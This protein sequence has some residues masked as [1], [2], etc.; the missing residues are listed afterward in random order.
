MKTNNFNLPSTVTLAF[1]LANAEYEAEMAAWWAE[2]WPGRDRAKH[3]SCTTLI[4]SPYINWLEKKYPDCPEDY[5]DIYFSVLGTIWHKW[6]EGAARKDP[7][8]A[9]VEHRFSV[10]VDGWIVSGKIDIAR[11]D[12]ATKHCTLLM[13]F[14]FSSFYRIQKAMKRG[15]ATF[16][17]Q[18]N[19]DCWLMRKAGWTVDAVAIGATSRDWTKRI[20]KKENMNFWEEIRFPLWGEDEQEAYVRERLALHQSTLADMDKTPPVC[21]DEERWIRD[22]K[23]A[24]MKQGIKNSRKNFDT[25]EEAQAWMDDQKDKALMYL[26]DR[27]GGYPR[28]EEDGYCQFSKAGL[29]HYYKIGD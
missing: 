29:C 14:K 15:S 6:L 19:T 23:T 22:P 27:P 10:D 16:E 9:M 21:T 5:A 18:L 2:T 11:G 25:T 8:N 24:V 28:C 20:L 17:A 7:T 3:L 26:E 12:L 1:D 4:D 13:D